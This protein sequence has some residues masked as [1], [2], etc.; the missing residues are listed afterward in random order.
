[1][2]DILSA[3]GSFQYE[4]KRGNISLQPGAI[5]PDLYVHVETMHDNKFRMTYVQLENSIV[6][7]LVNF[8][9]C[10]PIEKIPCFQIGYAVTA[11]YRN[12]GRAKLIIEMALT[13]MKFGYKRAGIIVFFVEAIVDESNKASLRVAEQT[14]CASPKPIIDEYSKMP[15]FQYLRKIE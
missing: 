15:S 9:L 7:A 12:Q 6:V 11:E 14:I 5:Y 3:L 13:E 8:V 10:A 1:M 2:V 4:F